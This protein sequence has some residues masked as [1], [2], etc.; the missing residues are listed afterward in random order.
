MPANL[1]DDGAVLVHPTKAF[2]LRHIPVPEIFDE[3]H[4]EGTPGSPLSK[5]QYIS[6]ARWQEIQAGESVIHPELYDYLLRVHSAVETL[7]GSM[8]FELHTQRTYSS[9]GLPFHNDYDEDLASD[10]RELVRMASC[11]HNAGDEDRYLYF[12]RPD[13][14]RHVEEFKLLIP[15][16]RILAFG[17]QLAVDYD[18]GIP[19]SDEAGTYRSVITRFSRWRDADD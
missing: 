3:G 8:E 13:W 2:I 4:W 11:V 15:A 5:V 7:F 14:S 17:G 6:K 12:Q 9:K 16:G 1:V 18:H 19:A 10:D